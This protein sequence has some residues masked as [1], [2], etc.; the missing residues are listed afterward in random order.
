MRDKIILESMKKKELFNFF[1]KNKERRILNFLNQHDVYQ[2][3][4]QKLFH[5]IILKPE[6]MN[7]IDG[8]VLSSFLS[9]FNFKN[10]PRIRGPTFSREFLSD[11]KVSENKRHFFIGFEKEGI[12]IFKKK[13]PHLK[14]IKAHNPPYVKGLVFPESDL[15]KMAKLI[16]EDKSDVVW[17]GLG[18]P[19]QNILTDELFKRTNSQYFFNTGAA[20][21]FLIGKKRE[22]PAF[23][24]AVGVEWLYRLVTDFKHTKKK[25]ARSFVALFYLGSIE[26][27]K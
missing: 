17:N 20:L 14:N 3:N 6:N 8:A 9:F 26:L 25:V 12:D 21:D 19:K 13:F 24:R 7:F 11:K 23:V 27:R 10:I 5:K 22:A 1:N 16:N 2:F 15:N 4:R 18:C